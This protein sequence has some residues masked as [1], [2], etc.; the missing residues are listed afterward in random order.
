MSDKESWEDDIFSYISI[1]EE[2][3]KTI[4]DHAD[5]LGEIINGQT[6]KRIELEGILEVTESRLK[7]LRDAIDKHARW[8]WEH[9]KVIPLVDEELYKARKEV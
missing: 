2:K 9:E 4:Q 5:K 8:K 7:I 3:V 6:M 1:L